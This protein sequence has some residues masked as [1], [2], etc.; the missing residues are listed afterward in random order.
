M[1]A[2]AGSAPIAAPAPVAQP[3]APKSIHP[4]SRHRLQSNR[5]GP[6]ED[7]DPIE[8]H[9]DG[10]LT[11]VSAYELAAKIG[12]PFVPS[13]DQDDG[14]GSCVRLGSL[15]NIQDTIAK[16]QQEQAPVKKVRRRKGLN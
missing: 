8:M 14:N 3:R 13:L 10:E 11:H 4:A 5:K 15:Q 2:S 6:D 16:I 1:F 9:N 7:E 12:S